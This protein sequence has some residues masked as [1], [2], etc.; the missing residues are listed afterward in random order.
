M[1]AEPDRA[2]GAL[3]H[4]ADDRPSESAAAITSRPGGDGGG[5][6]DGCHAGRSRCA[7]QVRGGDSTCKT[8]SRAAYLQSTANYAN[9]NFQNQM[10]TFE[11]QFIGS[12]QGP[13]S[14]PMA[15]YLQG[16]NATFNLG[17]QN[18]LAQQGLGQYN[19][20]QQNQL[21]AANAAMTGGLGATAQGIGAL[22]QPQQTQQQALNTAL[23]LWQQ[24]QAY[25]WQAA[26]GLPNL[27]SMPQGQSTT[28]T[29][30]TQQSPWQYLL[31]MLFG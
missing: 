25:P 22:A 11:S 12:G 27:T 4:R 21:G 14:T 10:P 6:G 8:R 20:E 23:G 7:G 24:Q 18:Q 28:G 16:Q 19:Q 2:A 15:Q 9:Q 13:N 17:L 3:V 30:T 1:A 29:T 5:A 26:L 31:P